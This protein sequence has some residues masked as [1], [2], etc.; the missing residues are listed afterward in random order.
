MRLSKKT[1]VLLLALSTLSIGC[2][3][4]KIVI[5]PLEQ[6]DIVM[7]SKGQTVVAPKDGAF[8][9]TEYISEVM[10]ARIEK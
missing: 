2:S 1:L 6:S 5:H 4:D 9:S 7:L 3:W 8:L 10:K